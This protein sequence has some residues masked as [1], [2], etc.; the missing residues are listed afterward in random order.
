MLLGWIQR[1]ESGPWPPQ[2]AMCEHGTHMNS[3][4]RRVGAAFGWRLLAIASVFGGALA[5]ERRQSTY[6][7]FEDFYYTPCG[8]DFL[9]HVTKYVQA[10]GMPIIHTGDP[11]LHAISYDRCQEVPGRFFR[12]ELD[13]DTYLGNL[14]S[15]FEEEES[16]M[17][18]DFERINYTLGHYRKPEFE[19]Q[20]EVV[21]SGM[22]I[23]LPTEC[24]QLDDTV[25]ASYLYFDCLAHAGCGDLTRIPADI[26]T[27]DVE[28]LADFVDGTNVTADLPPFLGSCGDNCQVPFWLGCGRKTKFNKKW[29]DWAALLNPPPERGTAEWLAMVEEADKLSQYHFDVGSKWCKRV[30][31]YTWVSCGKERLHFQQQMERPEN[32]QGFEHWKAD[33][34]FCPIGFAAALYIR[35]SERLN[36]GFFTTAAEDSKWLRATLGGCED[37]ADSDI[38]PCLLEHWPIVEQPVHTMFEDFA[39]CRSNATSVA[40]DGPSE[41]CPAAVP[42]CSDGLMPLGIRIVHALQSFLS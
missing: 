14:T 33:S 42:S 27:F 26:P 25:L 12:V 39:R 18:N 17:P 41:S 24:R 2:P 32:W 15:R 8:S 19:N 36:A 22:A 28:F 29:F 3:G 37:M 35:I 13:L 38:P 34:G 20:M 6:Q 30:T 11:S 10:S 21:R 5:N 4:F 1:H 40:V 9:N 16:L 7:T 23:C 31:G